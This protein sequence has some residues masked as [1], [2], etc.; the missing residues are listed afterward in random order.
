MAFNGSTNVPTRGEMV[1]DL[2]RLGLAFGAD[3]NA[4]TGFDATTYKFDLPKSDD[5]T[6]D[7]SLMLLREI[8]GNLTLNQADDG[9]GARRD[10]L[11]GAAARHARPT[12]SPRRGSAS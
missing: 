7:T 6:V 2:E 12:A 3:T 10:P 4:Q 1:K 8:A 11:R 5:Q 9:Q